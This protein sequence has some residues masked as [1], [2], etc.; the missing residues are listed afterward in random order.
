MKLLRIKKSQTR[1][2][3]QVDLTGILNDPILGTHEN[4]IVFKTALEDAIKYQSKKFAKHCHPDVESSIGDFPISVQFKNPHVL[5]EYISILN[6][7]NDN[8]ERIYKNLINSRYM[9]PIANLNAFKEHLFVAILEEIVDHNKKHKTMSFIDVEK[10]PYTLKIKT[11]LKEL[12]FFHSF[13]SSNFHTNFIECMVKQFNDYSITYQPNDNLVVTVVS[14]KVSSIVVTANNQKTIN[15]LA[16][17]CQKLN[18]ESNKIYDIATTNMALGYFQKEEALTEQFTNLIDGFLVKEI[19]EQ[20][21]PN[22]NT[23]T[24]KRLKI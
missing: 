2:T 24:G 21:L 1:A 5:K 18:K 12:N 9:T 17:I 22:N 14:D 11:N 16:Q 20:H 19:M 23:S 4:S 15:N 13:V 3:L 8:S 6:S 7:I 10:S